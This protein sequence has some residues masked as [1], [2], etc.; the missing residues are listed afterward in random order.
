MDAAAVRVATN[1]YE[2]GNLAVLIDWLI[3]FV[4]RSR[5]KSPEDTPKARRQR[6]IKLAHERG[7][8]TKAASAS[9]AAAPRDTNTVETTRRKHPSEDPAAIATGKAQAEQ[10]AGTTTMDEEAQPDGTNEPLGHVQGHIQEVEHLFDEAKLKA[11]I[12]KADPQSAAGPSGLRY[13]HLQAALCDEQVA[14]N[15]RVRHACRFSAGFYPKSFGACTRA[16][17]CL[18]WDKRRDRSRAATFSEGLLAPIFAI[19]TARTSRTISSPGSVPGCSV[20]WGRDH[21]TNSHTG[22]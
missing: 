4:G 11:I 6:A 9:S 16:P 5:R 20:R 14:G 12:K 2:E 8:I 1:E 17:I 7:G 15:R 19:D 18:R 13:S 21:G 22:L 3:V 10:R